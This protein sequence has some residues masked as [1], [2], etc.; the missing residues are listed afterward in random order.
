MTT[1]MAVLTQTLLDHLT[2]TG[3]RLP[4]LACWLM[5]EVWSRAHYEAQSP[6]QYLQSGE[7]TVNELEEVIAAAAG[8]IYEELLTPPFPER[9]LRH[10]LTAQ[11]PC[12]AVIFD[13]LS[14]RELPL[15][16]Q[17]AESSGLRLAE[18]GWSKAALPSE[19]LDF[20][21]QRLGVGAVAPSQLPGNVEL[22]R[23]G[24]AC[25]HLDQVNQQRRFDPSA[26][27]LLIW[28]AF[29]DYR[30][31]ERDAKFVELFEQLHHMLMTAWENSVQEVLRQAPGR[32]L[33]ITSDHGY[34]YFG[35]GC[36]VP[37]ENDAIRPLT[38]YLGGARSAKL[39]ERPN[40]PDHRGLAVFPERG[41]AVV[42]GRVQTHPPGEPA[43][44]LYKHGGLSL[45]EMLTPWLVFEVAP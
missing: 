11:Q 29:P 42:R 38:A 5:E 26:Q 9:D 14:L 41:V 1:P 43:R 2:R 16:Q 23:Q 10:F 30:Y 32:R 19:T 21:A 34:A 8:R 24:I 12:A 18:Q 15:L 27:A 31:K 44:K 3:R 36:S 22:A 7:R 40:P 20:V 28:S 4:W 17:L 6:A 45:M 25:Y 13:G 37:W 35:P 39:A 33:L